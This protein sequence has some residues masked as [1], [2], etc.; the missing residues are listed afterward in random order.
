VST[1]PKIVLRYFDVR[2]R[3]QFIRYYFA[4]RGFQYEDERVPI[5]EG[6]ASWLELR[7]D[8]TRTG[9]FQKLPVVEWEGQ[10]IPEA[11][12]IRGFVHEASG[13]AALLSPQDNLRHALL[14][15][16]AYEDI[17]FPVILLIWADAFF[18]G[19]DLS[20]VSRQSLE[21]TARHLTA[22]DRTLGEWQWLEGLAER[23]IM[24][25]DCLLWEELSVAQRVF[26]RHLPL[27]DKPVLARFLAECPG[28]EAFEAV[29][30]DHPCQIS[31]RVE[32][33]DAISQIQA[34][35]AE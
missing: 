33:A 4:C 17:M 9:P 1:N 5:G 20:K 25:A 31:G 34:A 23:P 13:D 6:Y 22:L 16:S 32:E 28:R 26:G 35:L 30:A 29:L 8:R 19:C 11:L 21:N 27:D 7:D 10:L 24:L 12:V 3:A 14:A 2:G 15:S 18:R